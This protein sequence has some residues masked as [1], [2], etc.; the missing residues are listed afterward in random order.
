MENRKATNKNGQTQIHHQMMLF[1]GRFQSNVVSQIH[2][3]SLS[4][5]TCYQITG[6][7][8]VNKIFLY[9]V[10]ITYYSYLVYEYFIDMEHG[11]FEA[12]FFL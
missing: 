4:L 10:G 5:F 8:N 11:S 9:K 2:S 12:S 6:V 1:H 7:G 3:S